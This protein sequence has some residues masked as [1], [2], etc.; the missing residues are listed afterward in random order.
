MPDIS[1]CQDNNCPKK[2]TCYRFTAIPSGDYQTYGDFQWEKYN[3][4]GN[5]C[6]FYCKVNCTVKE[7]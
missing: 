1:M 7:K 5:G 6:D 4:D 2:D 3:E